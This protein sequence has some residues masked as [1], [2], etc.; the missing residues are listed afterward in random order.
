MEKTP[1]RVFPGSGE[2]IDS[3][4]A[5]SSR[6]IRTQEDNEGNEIV[7]FDEESFHATPHKWIALAYTDEPTPIERGDVRG[8]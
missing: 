5:R 6:Q 3:D 8:R 4:E 1:N 7:V 2:K